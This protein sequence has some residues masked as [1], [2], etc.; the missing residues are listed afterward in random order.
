MKGRVIKRA[1]RRGGA[2]A[3][4]APGEKKSAFGSFGGFSSA[5]KTD[6]S[7]AFSFLAKSSSDSAPEKPSP[8]LFSFGA[9]AAAPGGRGTGLKPAMSFGGG[10]GGGAAA[11]PAFSFG[12]IPQAESR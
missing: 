3:A 11:P 1:R 10:A 12:S 6:A 2:E 5:A 4:Q 8:G 9:A 7:S